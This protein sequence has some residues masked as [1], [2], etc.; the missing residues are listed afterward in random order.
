MDKSVNEKRCPSGKLFLTMAL[1]FSYFIGIPVTS[2]EAATIVHGPR[3]GLVTSNEA[4]IYWDTNVSAK[5]KIHYGKTLDYGSSQEETTA[6]TNH[7]LTVQGLSAETK[8]HYQVVTEDAKSE[9]AFT[10]APTRHNAVF[11]FATMGDNRG[12]SGIED[13]EGLPENFIKLLADMEKRDLAFAFNTGDLFYGSTPDIKEMRL[14][15]ASFKRATD[16]LAKKVPYLVSPGNHEMSPYGDT[17]PHPGFYPLVL[18]NEQF[19]Q[20]QVLKGH[21]GTVFSW[22]WGNAHFSSVDTDLYAHGQPE[23]GFCVVDDNQIAWLEHD[24]AQ[25]QKRGVRHL[26]VLSHCHAFRETGGELL[27]NQGSVD[28]VQRDKFWA[29]LEKYKVDAYIT[30]HEHIFIDTLAQEGGEGSNKDFK[31]IQWLNGNCGAAANP[32]EYTLWTVDG[33]TVKAELVDTTGKV[34]YTKIFSSRQ[35]PVTPVT[36]SIFLPTLFRY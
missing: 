14:Q 21:E 17:D 8:Y 6:R 28:P 5:G 15:Y 34:N 9:G 23:N 29:V 19:A 11:K 22:N 30:G 20:P 4:T 2:L 26:F 1:L 27:Y 18:W 10:T 31:V 32:A 3:I 24:L 33:D 7:R 25:A 35:S 12:L 13:I 36:D 16:P